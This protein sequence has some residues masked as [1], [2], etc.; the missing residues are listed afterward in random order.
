MLKGFGLVPEGIEVYSPARKTMQICILI[1]SGCHYQRILLSL[2]NT[3]RTSVMNSYYLLANIKE[4]SL[5]AS[6]FIR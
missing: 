4:R 6:F 2:Q 3:L 5:T 1:I